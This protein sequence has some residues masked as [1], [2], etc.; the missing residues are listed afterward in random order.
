VFQVIVA[1]VVVSALDVSAE[2]T[3]AAAGVLGGGGGG[4]GALVPPVQLRT[5]ME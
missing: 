2:I 1:D 3:G 5:V 4:G